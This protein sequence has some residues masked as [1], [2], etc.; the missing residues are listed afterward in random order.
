MGFSA[1]N[2]RMTRIV[3][4]YDG[5]TGR[6]ESKE[7]DKSGPAKAFYAKMDANGRHPR[8]VKVER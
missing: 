5:A 8:I 2:S 7:F 3:V 4:E 6:R 1:W